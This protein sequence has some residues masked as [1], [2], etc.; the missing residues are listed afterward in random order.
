MKTS[1]HFFL[2]LCLMWLLIGCSYM[3]LDLES[4]SDISLKDDEVSLIRQGENL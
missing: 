2:P 4:A 3:D 1:I